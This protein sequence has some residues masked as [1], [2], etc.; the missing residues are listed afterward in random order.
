[1]P[2]IKTYFV[3]LQDGSRIGPFS[4][5]G[6]ALQHKSG[7]IGND[8]L[9]WTE[10]AP[11]GVPFHALVKQEDGNREPQRKKAT[12][13]PKKERPKAVLPP[14]K[15]NPGQ[16]DKTDRDDFDSYLN[17]SDQNTV[18]GNIPSLMG[19]CTFFC[20]VVFMALIL[21]VLHAYMAGRIDNT[22]VFESDV[23]PAL[24]QYREYSG[25]LFTFIYSLLGIGAIVFFIWLYRAASNAFT[26]TNGR[27]AIPPSAMI[28][29]WFIP[30]YNLLA[31]YYQSRSLFNASSD[32]T[33]PSYRKFRPLI[34]L[35]LCLAFFSLPA[36]LPLGDG[37]S[38]SIESA[39]EFLDITVEL[40]WVLIASLL[41][42]MLF[43]YTVSSRQRKHMV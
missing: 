35:W 17:A 28:I 4:Y 25:I 24:E 26:L 39:R 34:V 23:F 15:N 13:P 20:I 11:E 30:F 38:D 12:L 5:K 14:P 40:D 31:V 1:M 36:L 37:D 42:T 19:R 22:I 33:A 16:T 43:V 8:D 7:K 18:D 41:S 27:F 29:T 21:I 2:S 9:V 10:E 32:P 3:T 6:L